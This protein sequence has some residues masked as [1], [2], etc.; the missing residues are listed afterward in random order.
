MNYEI[1]AICLSGHT[2]T[3]NVLHLEDLPTFCIH[4]GEKVI[5]ACPSCNAPIH[6]AEKVSAW[7]SSKIYYEFPHYCHNCGKAYPWIASAI[8]SAE[9]LIDDE[10]QEL[11][12]EE[13]SKFKAALPCIVAQTPKTSL[14]SRRVSKFLKKVAPTAQET[15]KQIFYRFA[16]DVAKSI[17]WA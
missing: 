12:T 13:K 6:G 2:I 9:M 17:L 7:V 3:P 1:A 5:I 16:T 10:M 14:A 15:F 8:E 11:N 4:C